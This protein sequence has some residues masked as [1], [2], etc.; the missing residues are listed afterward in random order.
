MWSCLAPACCVH[1]W[2]VVRAG[3]LCACAAA[4]VK[5]AVGAARCCLIACRVLLTWRGGPL[6]FDPPLPTT[7]TQ[8]KAMES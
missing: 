4:P 1:V 7:H 8:A 6:V 5:V 2:C 3:H